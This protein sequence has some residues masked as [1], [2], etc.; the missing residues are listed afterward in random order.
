MVILRNWSTKGP[1]VG[2]RLVLVP[3]GC[4][5]KCLTSRL[6][7][8]A[9]EAGEQPLA[10][11]IKVVMT[12]LRTILWSGSQNVG[13]SPW[14]SCSPTLNAPTYLPTLKSGRQLSRQTIHVG[15]GNARVFGVSSFIKSCAP[16]SFCA[17]P[18]FPLDG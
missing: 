3:M 14:R 13:H 11:R 16:P 9:T 12:C 1:R 4:T 5:V 18:R 10:W 7:G 15:I 17:A 2:W 6:G 8:Q